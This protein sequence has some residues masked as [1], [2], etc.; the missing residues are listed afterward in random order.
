M[1]V[2]VAKPCNLHKNFTKTTGITG[3][4]RP[5]LTQLEWLLLKRPR[6]VNKAYYDM[7]DAKMVWREKLFGKATV[8]DAIN[9]MVWQGNGLYSMRFGGDKQRPFS[10]KA[11]DRQFHEVGHICGRF[12]HTMQMEN[13]LL[14]FEEGLLHGPGMVT[15]TPADTALLHTS[16][17]GTEEVDNVKLGDKWHDPIHGSPSCL[18][19]AVYFA[20]G[21]YL[22]QK[23][24]SFKRHGLMQV[25]YKTQK[26]FCLS[27]ARED[28]FS[29]IWPLRNRDDWDDIGKAPYALIKLTRQ[30]WRAITAVALGLKQPEET[31]YGGRLMPIK[32]AL[33]H[34][35]YFY[36]AKPE[37]TSAVAHHAEHHPMGKKFDMAKFE[38]SRV[39]LKADER[40]DSLTR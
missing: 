23:I 4:K 5:M 21:M 25:P 13:S 36:D 3:Y 40:R 9:A 2:L 34:I 12:G 38:A 39:R 17:K 18:D 11:K 29:S 14:A 26:A 27:Y 16:L 28:D 32:K 10:D 15:Y 24:E 19:R 37:F 22:H 35:G 20:A 6:R 30:E 1:S 7:I 31:P 8:Q 33:E